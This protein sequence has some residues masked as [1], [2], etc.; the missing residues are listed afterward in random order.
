MISQVFVLKNI[1]LNMDPVLNGY[2]AV[3]FFL[4]IVNVLL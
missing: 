3:G 4:I 1:S 2:G